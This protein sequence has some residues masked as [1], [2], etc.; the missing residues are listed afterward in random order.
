[1]PNSFEYLTIRERPSLDHF[2]WGARSVKYG[3]LGWGQLK[4]SE[5]KVCQF[6]FVVYTKH[7]IRFDI[8][9][10]PGLVNS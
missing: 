2:R 6:P 1:M 8:S 4:F 9:V 3:G 7:V 10:P 5:A